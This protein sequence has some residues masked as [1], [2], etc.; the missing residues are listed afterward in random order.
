MGKRTYDQDWKAF[1]C[2]NW[3]WKWF[4]VPRITVVFAEKTQ[5]SLS[6]ISIVW[7]VGLEKLMCTSVY[8]CAFIASDL[9][10]NSHWDRVASFAKFREMQKMFLRNDFREKW[11]RNFAKTITADF[12]PFLIQFGSKLG[13]FWD[14]FDG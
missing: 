2:H 7:S 11:M 10:F 4:C 13:P 6:Y 8:S 14:V 12:G 1:P 3:K 5:K 9:N